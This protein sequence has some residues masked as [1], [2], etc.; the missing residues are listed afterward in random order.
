MRRGPSG[1]CWNQLEPAGL[2]RAAA[3]HPPEGFVPLALPDGG[4]QA[5][6]FAAPFDLL[7]TL[8]APLRRRLRGLPLFSAWGRLLHWRTAFVG[9]TVSEY[10]L[11]PRG[12][13]PG[14]LQALPHCWAAAWS[15]G[16]ALLVAKDIPQRSP[17]LS[18]DENTQAEALTAACT[19]AGY[20]LLEGQALAHVPIDFD[21]TDTY[22]QRLSSSRRKNL[23]RK[24]R[25][26]EQLLVRAVPTGSACFDDDAVV[27]AHYVL[28]L[29]VHAQSELHFDRLTR[30]FFAQLL[31]DRT[32]GGIV[33]SYTLRSNPDGPLL[34]WNLCFE[35]RGMLIDKYIGL[36]YPHARDHDLYFVSWFVN[37][38][39]ALQRGLTH[40]VAGWT[41]PEVKAQLGAQFTFTRHAVY[42]A[43]PLLRALGRR[44]ARFFEADSR[45]LQGRS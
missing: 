6:A 27:D 42:I 39:H 17:L 23:R 33:F 4:P 40:Y 12:L 36:A 7:T 34:G 32:S 43:N 26:R 14:A 8:D 24:L 20:L 38:E 19:A 41:D 16:H 35:S 45:A 25:S 1:P 21:S 10:L 37:L 28:Y 30:G 2:L 9:S 22:L 15:T 11:L 13:Q 31:R 29:A 3:A 5:P 18:D 44:L